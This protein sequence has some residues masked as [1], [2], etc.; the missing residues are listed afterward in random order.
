MKCDNDK[1]EHK[2]ITEGHSLLSAANL[3]LSELKLL[4][5]LILLNV[6]FPFEGTLGLSGC[7]VKDI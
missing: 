6:L 7:V 5:T 1:I 2:S 3:L 4:S